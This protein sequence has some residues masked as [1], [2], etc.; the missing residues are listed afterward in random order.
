MVDQLPQQPWF[1]TGTYR[2][3]CHRHRHRHE[4]HLATSIARQHACTYAHSMLTVQIG[5][6]GQSVIHGD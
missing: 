5:Y 3:L 4:R 6:E 2:G 1:Q